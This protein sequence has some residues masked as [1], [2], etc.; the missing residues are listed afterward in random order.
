MNIKNRSLTAIAVS[1]ALVVGSHSAL[2]KGFSDKVSVDGYISQ[3][4]QAIEA[5]NGA[6]DPADAN[7]DTGF[8]RFRFALGFNVNISENVSA[9]IE[10]SEEPDDFGACCNPAIDLALI[11]IKLSEY[12]TFQIGTIVTGIFNFRG[13]SDGAVVQGNPLIGNSPADMVTAAEGAKFIG[14]SGDLHWELG[15]SGS[16]FGESFGGDRGYTFLGLASYNITDSIGI[17]FGFS[18]SNHGD[19]LGA[20]NGVGFIADPG[21][22][23]A[24]LYGGD[25]EN[26]RF[27][28][29][30]GG[31]IRN[32]HA[33]LIPG[34]DA[35]AALVDAQYKTDVFTV[36]GWYGVAKDDYSFST[37][38]GVQTVASQTQGFN[39]MESEMEFL[40]LEGIFNVTDKLYGAL[41][42]VTV[43]NE[44]NGVSGG[45]L[46]RIQ[47]GIG[48]W[49]NDVSLMKV[50]Y[51][52][53]EEEANSPG[54]IGDDWDGL[55]LELSYRF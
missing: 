26:Y 17:G 46:T 37:V 29:A 53:Q 9:F 21:A 25:G 28:S 30:G 33:G 31:G 23:R 1:A 3:G 19:Q 43:S 14:N 41:R 44:S 4:F 40:G 15:V 5:N 35:S 50:E 32:T 18:N 27:P 13:F 47:A 55:N 11:D 51:V 38:G 24:G 12:L 10:L 34:L 45:D 39:T 36:R 54:Q 20:A 6:F 7:M 48:M 42:Y 49:F 52:T 16:D 22:V 8:N 2:A